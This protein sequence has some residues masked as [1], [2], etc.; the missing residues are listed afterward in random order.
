MCQIHKS[1]TLSF[2]GD[3]DA[4]ILELVVCILTVTWYGLASLP[5]EA[6]MKK[7]HMGLEASCPPTISA[8]WW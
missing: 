4:L 2:P 6:E 5:K 8:G 7:C 3:H 1:T